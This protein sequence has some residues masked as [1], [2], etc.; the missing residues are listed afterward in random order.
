MR[1]LQHARGFLQSKVAARLQTRYT[2]T[3]VFSLDEGVKKSI[4]ISRLID[5]AIAAD[6]DKPNR[7]PD[8]TSATP[9]LQTDEFDDD[10]EEDD[11]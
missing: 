3:L 10:D 8:E 2:P 9:D 7:N 4:E 11:A 6:A 5:Q 1:G